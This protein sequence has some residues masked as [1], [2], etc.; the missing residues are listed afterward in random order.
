MHIEDPDRARQKSRVKFFAS[1]GLCRAAKSARSLG[2]A[3]RVV[4][5]A[6]RRHSGHF[7]P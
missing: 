1:Q 2:Q 4:K 7:L 6:A 3:A 5:V